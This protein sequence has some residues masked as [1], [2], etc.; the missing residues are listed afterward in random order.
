MLPE[1]PTE[2]WER[3]LDYLWDKPADLKRC[4]AV[5]KAW[6]ARSYFHL[7]TSTRLVD[8][9]RTHLFTKLLERRPQLPARVQTVV[10]VGAVSS[11][12]TRRPIPHLGTFVLM[13]AKKLPSMY[14]LGIANA[15]WQP[16]TLSS[17]GFLHLST[18]FAC[19]T[20]LH[21]IYVTFP[22]KIFLARLVC[23]LPSLRDLGCQHLLFRSASFN[24][25]M[26]CSPPPQIKIIHLDGPSDDVVDLIVLH[27]GIAA[28]LEDVRAGWLDRSTA[29]EDCVSASA[30]AS[31]LQHTGATLRCIYIRLRVQPAAA[32][33]PEN[34]ADVS[35]RTN[36]PLVIF[37][38]C[39]ELQQ[40]GIC[41]TLPKSTSKGTAQSGSL[42]GGSLYDVISSIKS[43]KIRILGIRLDVRHID[44]SGALNLLKIALEFLDQQQCAKIDETLTNEQ[45]KT[46]TRRALWVQLMCSPHV[47]APDSNSWNSA[48]VA[49]FPQLHARGI[50]HTAVNV[51]I[52]G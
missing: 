18:G 52:Q 5:C 2:T 42:P 49:R 40:L 51:S 34:T 15:D 3:I 14:T 47:P 19:I 11:G 33:A 36:P 43:V 44:D 41:Y 48:M 13:L 17:S 9:H 21:L 1:M 28:T 32:V 31:L 37:D 30:V 7:V 22:S 46:R 35:P 16:S 24:P 39:T 20:Q 23:A 45:F 26:M 29:V 6:Y 10:I 27:L 12:E 8:P 50:L 38:Q 25:S 4:A